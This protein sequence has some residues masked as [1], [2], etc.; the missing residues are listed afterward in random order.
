MQNHFAKNRLTA[1]SLR[2]NIATIICFSLMILAVA[3]AFS[4]TSAAPEAPAVEI[5][6]P[7]VDETIRTTPYVVQWEIKNI[8]LEEIRR[9]EVL[10]DE[11][12]DARSGRQIEEMST[13]SLTPSNGSRPIIIR[14]VLTSGAVIEASRDVDYFPDLPEGMS[15]ITRGSFM[16]G[17]E[18]TDEKAFGDERPRHPVKTST[19]LIDKREVTNREY[20]ICVEAGACRPSAYADNDKW[21]KPD[22]PVVGVSWKDARAYCRFKGARLPTEA[23]WERAARGG[24]EVPQPPDIDNRAWLDSNSGYRTHP[25]GLKNPNPY[26]LYDMLGNVWEWC[27]DYY[28]ENYYLVSGERNPE[29]PKRKG[30][31]VIRGGGFGTREQDARFALRMW[32]KSGA[33]AVNIGFRCA[34]DSY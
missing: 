31:R 27:A 33:G 29:G 13:Y 26:G 21:N 10:Y 25:S 14:A 16:M 22:H 7:S 1:A 6:R 11:V 5:I 34:K 9:I 30:M 17:S 23:Q 15:R 2:Q 18:I 24:A 28:G 19:Y 3:T 20:Q 32:R 8:S 12:V 4:D